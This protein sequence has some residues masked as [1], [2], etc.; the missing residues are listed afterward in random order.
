M[1]FTDDDEHAHKV[2][3]DAVQTAAKK[4]FF[5]I[6]FTLTQAGCYWQDFM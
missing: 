6:F 2:I 5:T 3:N 4:N 1:F